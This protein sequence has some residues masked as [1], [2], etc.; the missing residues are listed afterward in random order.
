VPKPYEDTQAQI[1]LMKTL[2]LRLVVATL[3][4]RVF[5]IVL[6]E[7]VETLPLLNVKRQIKNS[8]VGLAKA[9]RR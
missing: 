7:N 8:L 9:W 1:V 6:E 3:P 4:V 5:L 2:L